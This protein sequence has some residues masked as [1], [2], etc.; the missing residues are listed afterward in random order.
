MI[1]HICNPTYPSNEKFCH[2]LGIIS[3]SLVKTLFTFYTFFCEYFVFVSPPSFSPWINN[4]IR[5]W[6][7]WLL[8]VTFNDINFQVIHV[9]AHRCAG[10]LKKLDLR[11]G[12][13]AIDISYC[14]YTCLS[15]HR[16]GPSF[17]RLFRE[18]ATFQSPFTRAWGYLGP[19][20]IL[21]PRVPTGVSIS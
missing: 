14:S 11:S 8:K 16:H 9:S 4:L 15:K 19:F 1:W 17:L 5:G 10:R 2:L 18:S 3:L 13:H 21:N 6:V 7:Y 20:P 12:S